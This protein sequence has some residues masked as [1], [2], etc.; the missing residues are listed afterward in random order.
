VAEVAVCDAL[1]DLAAAL[2]GSLGIAPTGNI[3]PERRS[4]SMF[5]PIHGSAFDIAGKGIANPVATFW[6][7]AMNAGASRRGRRRRAGDAGGGAS[8]RGGR[9]RRE[10]A[11]MSQHMVLRRSAIAPAE[12]ATGFF[13]T[14]CLICAQAVELRSSQPRV[15]VTSVEY[16]PSAQALKSNGQTRPAG[17]SR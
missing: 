11:T 12:L 9:D 13:C 15:T 10:V 1:S 17:A 7:G 8:V 3:D 16:L 6:T 2:A 4:P 5:E 14:V